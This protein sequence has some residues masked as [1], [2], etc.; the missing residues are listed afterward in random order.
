MKIM[1]VTQIW[2]Y[3]DT[4]VFCLL[5]FVYGDEIQTCILSLSIFKLNWWYLFVSFVGQ[6]GLKFLVMGL[7]HSFGVYLIR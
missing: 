2:A 7:F 3:N 4:A 1:V 5:N 6:G